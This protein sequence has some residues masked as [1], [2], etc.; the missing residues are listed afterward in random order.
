VNVL[1]AQQSPTLFNILAKSDEWD[2]TMAPMGDHRGLEELSLLDVPA[3]TRESPPPDVVMVCTPDQLHQACRRFPSAQRLW[4]IHNGRHRR[5][6]DPRHESVISGVVTFSEKVQWLQGNRSVP[7]HFISPAYEAKPVWKWAPDKLWTLRNRPDTREDDLDAVIGAVCRGLD[8]TFYGQGQP[9]GFAPPEAIDTLRRSC[10]AHVS[11]LDRC[12]GFGLADHENFAAG[13]PV[14]GGW[15][16][17]LAAEMPAEY[18]GLQ[19]DLRAMA[20]AAKRVAVDPD[21]AA[22]LSQLGLDYI[23]KHRTRERMDE[24]I[25]DLQ[26]QL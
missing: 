22:Q 21:A 24:T 9:A 26:Q 19:H 4:V 1:V 18:W 6:L 3:F 8:H 20:I 17:D 23:R 13:V 2:M 7:V 11:G 5:L 16:G 25:R 15:W 10:S 14:I 12:A